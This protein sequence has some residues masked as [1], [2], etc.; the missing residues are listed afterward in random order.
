M[1]FFLFFFH[2]NMFHRISD[3][4]FGILFLFFNK[5]NVVSNQKHLNK[6]QQGAS[7]EYP[8]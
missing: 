4:S 6:A 7:Y 1:F 5:K 3:D 8:Q 2:D